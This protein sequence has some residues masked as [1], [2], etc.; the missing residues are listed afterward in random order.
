MSLSTLAPRCEAAEMQQQA[1]RFVSTC[2][3]LVVPAAVQD[4]MITSCRRYMA[5]N[6]QVVSMRFS[7]HEQCFERRRGSKLII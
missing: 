2:L 7:K 1:E 4:C 6:D 5:G 3:L